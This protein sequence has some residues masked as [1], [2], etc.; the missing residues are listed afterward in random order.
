M[1]RRQLPPAGGDIVAV[2]FLASYRHRSDVTTVLIDELSLVR[3]DGD[4]VDLR[5][6]RQVPD[7]DKVTLIQYA[8]PGRESVQQVTKE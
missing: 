8:G 3:I 7:V 2:A 5:S 1:L 4:A 6:F